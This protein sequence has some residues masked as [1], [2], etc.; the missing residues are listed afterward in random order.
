MDFTDLVNEAY[1]SSKNNGFWD[2]PRKL[3]TALALAVCEIA[4]AIE[5]DR[6]QLVCYNPRNILADYSNYMY[7]THVKDT[8]GDELAGCI[9]RLCDLAG[10]FNLDVDVS[11]VQS[12]LT[13]TSLDFPEFCYYIM[14]EILEIENNQKRLATTLGLIVGCAKAFKIELDVHIELALKYNS[15]RPKRHGKQY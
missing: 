6:Q 4:E 9:L 13:Y 8:V 10:G 5:A 7:K 15:S 14:R 11:N 12:H 1:Q 3:K 2:N